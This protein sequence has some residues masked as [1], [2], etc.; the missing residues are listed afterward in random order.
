MLVQP[1]VAVLLQPVLVQPMMAPQAQL[2]KAEL[3][4]LRTDLAF[5]TA[6]QSALRASPWRRPRTRLQL[7]PRILAVGNRHA[8]AIDLVAAYER[9][10]SPPPPVDDLCARKTAHADERGGSPAA[11]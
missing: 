4:W 5:E 6:T 10:G 9:C 7:A 1:V 8:V 11:P 3:P 2:L